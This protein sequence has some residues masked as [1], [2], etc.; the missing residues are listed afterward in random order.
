[1]VKTQ[2]NFLIAAIV[3]LLILFFLPPVNGLTS[4]GVR[5]LA[6]FIPT[7]II[8]LIEGGSGWSGL[9]ATALIVF[10]GVYNGAETYKLLWGGALVAL[11][12]PFYMIANALEECGAVMWVVRWILSR[13][14]VHGRP[15]LFTIL[16]TISL[17]LVSVMITPMVTV[18]IFFK[19]LKDLCESIGYDHDSDFYRA[20]GLIIAWIGQ[21]VDGCLIWGRPFILSMVAMI[22]G[23]GFERFTVND[24][25]RLAILYL[26]IIT[27]VSIIFVKFWIRP[28]CANFENYDD[29]AVREELKANPLNTR[30]KILLVAMLAVVFCY[31]GAFFTPLGAL[32]VYLGGLPAAAPVSLAVSIL[33]LIYITSEDGTK[34][35]VLDIGREMSRL[36]WNT[37]IFLGS[38]MFFGGIVGSEE[39]GISACLSNI[40]T[41]IVSSLSPIVSFVV[42]LAIASILTNLTSNAVS[43]MV[44]LS[45]FVPA[46]IAAPNIGMSQ[47]LAFC[48]CTVTI[49]ATAIATRAACATMSLVYCPDGIEYA[50]TAKYSIT[51]CAVMVLISALV[52]VPVGS[53]IFAGLV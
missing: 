21:A 33:A 38:V 6:V 25:F 51:L 47:V 46:M 9:M 1:M 15:T 10:L 5:F 4:V 39:F 29:A 20:H 41:P 40:I 43:C 8:W 50:G 37:I 24:F 11:C 30:S 3:G 49:C 26:I 28:N 35:P 13:K 12:I 17:I 42:G 16:F 7:V 14:I 2:R 27:I 48:V 45:C 34:K 52:L 31:V 22:V 32:Q 36:P 18:V 19:V 23:L 53:G 44:V